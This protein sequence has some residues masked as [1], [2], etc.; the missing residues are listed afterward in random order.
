MKNKLPLYVSDKFCVI[1]G[2][3]RNLPMGV[4]HQTLI[5]WKKGD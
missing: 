3:T 2:L 1:A 4:N 5:S